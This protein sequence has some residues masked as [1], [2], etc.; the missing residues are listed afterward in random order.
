MANPAAGD[1]H[2]RIAGNTSLCLDVAYASRDNG[3]NL[4][5]HTANYTDA[6]VFSL[7][8]E[9]GYAHILARFTG[10]SVDTAGVSQGQN[11]Q[12]WDDA[13]DR[14][15]RWVLRE[16]GSTITWNGST[17]PTYWVE[18]EY[19][20]SYVMEIEG[21]GTPSSGD[22]VCL[23]ANETSST[24][25]HWFFE[26]IPKY[27]DGGIYEIVS[28]MD[29][30]MRFD[31]EGL[32]RSNGAN[33]MIFTPNGGNNQ[34]FALVKD[35]EYWKLR[36]VQS[37]KNL[38]IEGGEAITYANICQ[39]DANGTDSQ[40]WVIT[41]YGTA[42]V[43]GV[44]CE[45]VTFGAASDPTL[46]MDSQ[47]AV[48]QAGSNVFL[49]PANQGSNQEWVLVPTYATDP[50][51]PSP[52]NLGIAKQVRGDGATTQAYEGAVDCL[53]YPT[54]SCSDAWA[55]PGANHYQIQYRT[56]DMQAMTSTWGEWSDWTAMHD[57]SV[58]KQ[59]SRSWFT[60]G[61]PISFDSA[62][63]K[64]M[65]V[66]FRVRAVGAD[67]YSN[68]Y[69][70]T[71]EQV[72][73]ILQA[74]TFALGDSVASYDGLHMPF[75]SDY[76]GSNVMTVTSL[77]SGMTEFLAGPVTL[78]L[79]QDGEALIPIDSLSAIPPA[80]TTLTV[81]YRR[82]TDMQEVMD[83]AFAGTSTVS[84]ISGGSDVTPTVTYGDGETIHV[85]VPN[86]G[87]AQ[88]PSVPRVWVVV[89]GQSIEAEYP[90]DIPYPLDV[91]Y[92]L[93]VE[94]HTAD[95]SSWGMA[96]IDMEAVSGD[97]P[98]HMF[99]W[100]G[101]FLGLRIDEKPM[102]VARSVDSDYGTYK[103]NGRSLDIA[104]FGTAETAK[105]TIKGILV[106]SSCSSDSSIT[107]DPRAVDALRR[108]HWATY[109]S[110]SGD[111]CRVAIMSTNVDRYRNLSVVT[112]NCVEVDS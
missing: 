35:G 2:I 5:V 98:T 70:A 110:I 4:M 20:P 96:S 58:T 41:E 85:D 112:I 57:I 14:H 64:G 66:A 54:W 89:D 84:Y 15:Q 67:M 11:V 63:V 105:R 3:G 93:V 76:N 51:M 72:C 1:Y 88:N 92:V 65:E 97:V 45:V 25:Q 108:A 50:N 32:S 33:L 37:G 59:G 48:A 77:K 8:Y 78:R 24:D 28:V 13:A 103:L 107:S 29:Y 83:G 56:R 22:N 90:F 86:I 87:T 16:T 104:V 73:R 111:Y 23:A 27:R 106:D 75:A 80:G 40:R 68:L 91:P 30:R 101:G 49:H 74:P 21:T 46:L 95:G 53:A 18:L 31:V 10:K 12:M 6:Q 26:P 19:A 36:C 34:K 79:Q 47:G 109:R 102:D 62:V 7:S 60:D 71:A 100:D 52:T 9:G 39:W 38:D 81:T 69:G 82:G 43:G 44:S 94:S 61:I 99:N 17:Y 55:A 42:D